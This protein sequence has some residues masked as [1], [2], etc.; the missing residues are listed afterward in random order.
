[1]KTANS[2]AASGNLAGVVQ[3]ARL[4]VA[5]AEHR[6]QVARQQARVAKRRCKEV[7]LIARRAKKQAKQ[8]KADLA[9][10][11][12][13]LAEA[14]AKLAKSA[15]RPVTS[16][17]ASARRRPVKKVAAGAP[18]GKARPARKRRLRPTAPNPVSVTE[19]QGQTESVPAQPGAGEHASAETK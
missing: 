15:A 14:E 2:K 4:R 5:S 7:K 12:K 6:R 10:A 9:E 13:V 3:M 17:S 1:M 8:A 19:V 16:K 18:G 11:R